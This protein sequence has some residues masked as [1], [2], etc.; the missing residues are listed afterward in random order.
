MRSS[1]SPPTASSPTSPVPAVLSRIASLP[2]PPSRR[3]L[4]WKHSGAVAGAT[5]GGG[6]L[7]SRSSSL[8]APP[9]RVSL[10]VPPSRRASPSRPAGGAVLAGGA[11]GRRGRG[12]RGGRAAVVAQ[13][14]VARPASERVVAGAAVEEVVAVAARDD[15]VARV[16]AH[17][18]PLGG[19]VEPVV[20]R[21]AGDVG[22]ER[23]GRRRERS[24]ER[25][26]G[27]EGRSRWS[28][29]H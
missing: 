20:A 19:A 15:V 1:P 27:K 28:P 25:R 6:Q 29:Y 21:R 22:G 14:V 7:S 23:E 4:P 8:P 2:G 24:E 18:V 12:A 10:P 26:V 9:A 11:L 3:S 17:D 13:L 5:T 16:G